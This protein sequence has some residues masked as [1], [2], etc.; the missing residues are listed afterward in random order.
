VDARA[1]AQLLA[2]VTTITAVL[3]I[4]INFYARRAIHSISCKGIQVFD[5]GACVAD[6]IARSSIGD[7]TEDVR[8]YKC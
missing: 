7:S 3:D 4:D 5:G 6:Y 8:Y 1:R 2:R